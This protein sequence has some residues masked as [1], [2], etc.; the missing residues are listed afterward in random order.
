M[1]N[2]MHGRTPFALVAVL[3]LA[4]CSGG[5]EPGHPD[6]GGADGPPADGAGACEPGEKRCGEEGGV[7]ECRADGFGWQVT[8][9]CPGDAA[10]EAGRCVCSGCAD[11]RDGQCVPMGF[12]TC[13]D[14]WTPTP[15]C[16]CEPILDDCSPGELPL[17]GGGC[18]PLG[19]TCPEGWQELSGGGCEPLLDDC[20][21]GALPLVGGGC[22]EVGPAGRRRSR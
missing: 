21:E 19:P 18:H 9:Q 14:G 11:F 7:E 10:C 15:H 20:N 2:E 8:A 6:G 5:T 12:A 13:P 16:G 1:R 22:R 17:M 4:A 3:L